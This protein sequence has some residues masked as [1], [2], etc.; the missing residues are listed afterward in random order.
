LI[1]NYCKKEGPICPI[2]KLCKK[3]DAE[4]EAS[5]DATISQ[6]EARAEQLMRDEE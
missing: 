3:C 2:S 5:I 6:N 1:C 4:A